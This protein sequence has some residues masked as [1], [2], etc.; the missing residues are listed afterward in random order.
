MAFNG[1]LALAVLGAAVAVSSTAGANDS[2]LTFTGDAR[3]RTERD[4]TYFGTTSENLYTRTRFRLKADATVNDQWNATARLSTGGNQY[5]S[6]FTNGS[7]AYGPRQAMTLDQAF[8]TY[9]AMDGMS[10]QL[11]KVPVSF[12]TAGNTVTAGVWNFDQSFE[13]LQMKWIG[14]SGAFKPYFTATYASLLEN[15]TSADLTLFGAQ[16]GTKWTS[17]DLS[18]NFAIGSYNFNNI[19]GSTPVNN[20]HS[21]T[22]SYGNGRGNTLAGTAYKYEYAETAV[23]A[24]VTYNAAFAPV[25]A[26]GGYITNN[27]GDAKTGM[28]GGLKVGALK[29]VGSWHA[30][31]TYKDFGADAFFAFYS[32]PSA[33]MG[34][35][36]NFYG[37]E[38]Q[39]GYQAFTAVSLVFNYHNTYHY[40]PA[41]GGRAPSDLYV[42]DVSA[43]F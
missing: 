26:F 4:M 43:T 36:S 31:A 37:S 28:F 14:D 32:E 35:G 41:L 40:I 17:D 30:S 16:L 22:T 21:G 25:Q 18:A 15:T 24:E 8:L 7:S 29:D 5:G 34:G 27:E 42:F 11:G 23:D 19:K 38:F 13:G 6:H 12:W 10:L 9:K 20:G 33:S 2:K 1:K 39:L 3:L